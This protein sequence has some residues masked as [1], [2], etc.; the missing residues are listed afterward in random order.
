MLNQ[1]LFKQD[2]MSKTGSKI[3]EITGC[4]GCPF[5]NMHWNAGKMD[6]C[7]LGAGQDN[8]FD[9]I[10]IP[11]SGILVDCPVKNGCVTVKL[12]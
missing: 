4:K 2:V 8:E 1:A 9:Y 6:Q 3:I 11:E 5:Q 12:K 7:N 10:R